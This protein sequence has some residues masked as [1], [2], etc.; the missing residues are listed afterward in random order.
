MACLTCKWFKPHGDMGTSPYDIVDIS[1][2]M[3]TKWEKHPG[4][5]SFNPV[6][7]DI[8]A[9]HSCSNYSSEIDSVWLCADAYLKN[10]VEQSLYASRVADDIKELKLKLA[11]SRKLSAE[12]LEKIKSLTAKLKET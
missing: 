10:A 3:N 1:K 5:C 11:N 6:W 9:G 7:E 12:R 8:Q 2:K 4:R